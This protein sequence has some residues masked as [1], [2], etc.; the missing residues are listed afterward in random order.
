MNNNAGVVAATRCGT[1]GRV[2]ERINIKQ[3]AEWASVVMEN[4]GRND[5]KSTTEHSK[6]ISINSG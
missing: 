2:G 5:T 4:A 1:N 3:G 6:G